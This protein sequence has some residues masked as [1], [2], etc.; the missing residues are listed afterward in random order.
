MELGLLIQK[1]WE[2][3]VAKGQIEFESMEEV[4]CEDMTDTCA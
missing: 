1:P 4:R 3:F 2:V